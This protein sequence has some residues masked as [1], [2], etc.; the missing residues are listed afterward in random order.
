[1]KVVVDQQ[2]TRIRFFGYK[3]DNHYNEAISNQSSFTKM[4]M[5][6]FVLLFNRQPQ[7]FELLKNRTGNARFLQP[8]CELLFDCK[9]QGTGEFIADSALSWFLLKYSTNSVFEISYAD[10]DLIVIKSIQNAG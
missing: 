1:M 10:Y 6:D 4:A 8:L 3:H 9:M 5:S 2:T 7:T